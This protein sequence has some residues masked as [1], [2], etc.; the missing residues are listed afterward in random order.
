MVALKTF[1]TDDKSLLI[2]SKGD[3]I[4]LQPM[5][6]L[7]VGEVI[8]KLSDEVNLPWLGIQ[9]RTAITKRTI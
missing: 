3:I 4:K 7:Q 8:I 2:F 5:E 6:G 9:A 1:T